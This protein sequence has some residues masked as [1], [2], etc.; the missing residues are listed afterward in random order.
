MAL[1]NMMKV[2]SSHKLQS[3]Q[4]HAENMNFY[5]NKRQVNSDSEVKQKLDKVQ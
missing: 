5:H 2:H 3:L 1:G 4:I